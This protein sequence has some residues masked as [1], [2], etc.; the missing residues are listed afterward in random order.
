MI[1]F[2]QVL[3]KQN[4][5]HK[6]GGDCA[7]VKNQL[8]GS[9]GHILLPAGDF[10]WF[11]GRVLSWNWSRSGCI[12][13]QHQSQLPDYPRNHDTPQRLKHPEV[14]VFPHW[15][16]LKSYCWTGIS[17]EGRKGE[18]P[19]KPETLWW[20]LLGS[21]DC[22]WCAACWKHI[23]TISQCQT[24][25]VQILFY[26]KGQTVPDGA[27]SS[28]SRSLWISRTVKQTSTLQKH[29]YIYLK[30]RCI[31]HLFMQTLMFL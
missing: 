28:T 27:G 5:G 24:T 3:G 18:E 25:F 15:C 1:H 26:S 10:L 31:M 22:L 11:R 8:K 4:S 29:Q 30:T 13:C 17:G 6:E 7:H 20:T 19:T 21:E 16:G 23:S 2:F 12:Q 9:E 14:C